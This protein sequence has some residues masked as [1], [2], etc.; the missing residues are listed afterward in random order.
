MGHG[1]EEEETNRFIKMVMKESMNTNIVTMARDRLK[2]IIDVEKRQ[3]NFLQT[4]QMV[5]LKEIESM[6]HLSNKI[7]KDNEAE[8]SS[9]DFWSGLL[10]FASLRKTQ[11][12]QLSLL[13][14]KFT[15]FTKEAQKL[16]KKR[17]KC[18]FRR[19]ST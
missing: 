3:L 4:Y 9:S 7:T 17:T 19:S 16:K 5:S 6:D 13:N 18:K 11:S 1:D 8:E 14:N 15:T 12:G 10:R 2:R